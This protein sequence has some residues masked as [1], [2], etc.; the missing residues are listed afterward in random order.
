LGRSRTGDGWHRIISI[1]GLLACDYG[2]IGRENDNGG[3]AFALGCGAPRRSEVRG[4]KV[5]KERQLLEA[6]RVAKLLR[7]AA[8]LRRFQRSTPNAQHFNEEGFVAR[9]SS[10][11][12]LK[13][14]GQSSVVTRQ[15]LVA[16]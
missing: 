8:M 2:E 9:Q 1:D 3:S 12:T 7:G 11:K 10:L 16:P 13:V 5:S 4:Q 14:R 15:K 6:C